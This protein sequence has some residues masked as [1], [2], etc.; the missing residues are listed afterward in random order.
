[1]TTIELEQRAQ[2]REQKWEWDGKA[3]AEQKRF[4]FGS[5]EVRPP[6]CTL[7]RILAK[8]SV[9][10]SQ[11]LEHT[12]SPLTLPKILASSLRRKNWLWAERGD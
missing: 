4:D 8:V 6:I 1:M 2:D 11:V 3:H 5:P 12:L 10:V 7:A 9:M